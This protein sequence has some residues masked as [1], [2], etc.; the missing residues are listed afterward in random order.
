MRAKL[1]NAGSKGVSKPVSAGKSL[2]EK[3]PVCKKDV[4]HT[5]CGIPVEKMWKDHATSAMIK[6]VFLNAMQPCILK[7][8]VISIYIEKID[9]CDN[10]IL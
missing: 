10:C 6:A 5:V 8:L 4:F 9:Q 3:A 1:R 2:I 7:G